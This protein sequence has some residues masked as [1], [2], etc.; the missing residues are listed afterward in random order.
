MAE[1]VTERRKRLAGEDWLLAGFR[2]L[3][4][5]G[6]SGLKAEGL[7]RDLGTT[8]GSF[9]WHF[10]D[11]PTFRAEMLA[12]WAARAYGDVI[13][14]VEAAPSPAARLQKLALLAVSHRDPAYGGAAVEPALRAWAREDANV[15]RAVAEMDGR[16]VNYV[17]ALCLGAGVTDPA[18]PHLLYAA[19]T[20]Y[21]D[22]DQ[23]AFGLADAE[24]GMLALLRMAGIGAA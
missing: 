10:A 12:Y 13:A 11:V 23:S 9:Y 2:A 15:A 6:P 22:F 16:R 19:S 21:A 24:A 17:K 3:V 14:Q 1:P 8:K 7:A 5:Q 18:L 4:R 20:G